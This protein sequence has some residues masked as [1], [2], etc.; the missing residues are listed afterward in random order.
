ML[1]KRILPSEIKKE[2]PKE[3]FIIRYHDTFRFGQYKHY[4]VSYVI[5]INPSY[6]LWVESNTHYTLS[7][8][9]R[10]RAEASLKHHK[11]LAKQTSGVYESYHNTGGGNRCRKTNP[12]YAIDFDYDNDDCMGCV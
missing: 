10:R 2:V 1:P 8:K 4:S 5:S 3:A 12:R 7:E 6:L 11:R 9:V